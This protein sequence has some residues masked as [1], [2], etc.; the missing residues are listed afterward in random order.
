MRQNALLAGAAEGAV[1]LVPA[2][3]IELPSDVQHLLQLLRWRL[4]RQRRGWADPD[5]CGFFKTRRRARVWQTAEPRGVYCQPPY[6]RVDE[7]HLEIEC[8]LVAGDLVLAEPL[9][10]RADVLVLELDRSLRTAV[11]QRQERTAM[12]RLAVRA[13]ED[14]VGQHREVIRDD[15]IVLLIGPRLA[16]H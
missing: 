10:N 4:V 16:R 8:R 7:R 2:C 11:Q 13:S 15:Q 6:H 1:A 3:H 12:L 14:V 9:Q 5:R